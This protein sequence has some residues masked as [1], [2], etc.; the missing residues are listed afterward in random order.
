MPTTPGF[1][2]C[3]VQT[4]VGEQPCPLD[5]V[6]FLPKGYTPGKRYPTMLFLNE[7]DT[8]GP[9]CGGICLHGPDLALARHPELADPF[10][11]IVVSPHLPV[12]CDW[13]TGR[14]DAGPAGA[15]GP[16]GRRRRRHRPGPGDGD[17]HRRRRER[18]LAAG[19]RR[20][21]TVSR[22]C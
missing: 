7:A 1:H 10:G 19:G 11:F 12:K 20:A 13:Q 4:K 9:D 16:P 5:Y 6:V 22:P 3:T 17:R 14:H 18:G 8:V 2:F 21:R 15:A